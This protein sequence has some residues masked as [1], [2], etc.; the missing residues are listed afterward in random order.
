MKS[1]L[2]ALFVAVMAVPVLGTAT[3][4]RADSGTST[5][6]PAHKHHKHCRHHRHHHKKAPTTQPAS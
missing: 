3:V 4:A 1:L 2:V 6:Q 5:T